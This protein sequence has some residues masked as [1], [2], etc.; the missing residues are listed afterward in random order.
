MCHVAAATT[1]RKTH[2]YID[3]FRDIHGKI[4]VPSKTIQLA[5]VVSNEGLW[6]PEAIIGS[7]L[8]LGNH[9]SQIGTL[10]E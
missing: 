7:H 9:V 3:F 4:D 5:I 10:A 6:T 2:K 8:Y 1:K